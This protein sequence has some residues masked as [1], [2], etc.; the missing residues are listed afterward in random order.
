MTSEIYV[1]LFFD[2]IILFG[3]IFFQYLV[4][5]ENAVVEIKTNSH[6]WVGQKS[7][8]QKKRGEKE[9]KKNTL[10]LVGLLNFKHMSV[11]HLC[12]R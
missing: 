4:C 1:H 10:L 8:I 2:N 9:K 11:M 12:W 3:Y 6:I 7:V 5:H